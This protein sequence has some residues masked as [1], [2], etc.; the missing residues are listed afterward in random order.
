MS[1]FPIV[2]VQD[3]ERSARFYE[4]AFG[5]EPTFRWPAQGGPP[6]YV[7]L[8]RGQSH[9]GIGLGEGRGGF[10]LCLYVED[11]DATAEPQVHL[12]AEQRLGHLIDRK[13]GAH[14][15][16]AGEARIF[17]G[18][19]VHP[20]PRPCAVRGDEGVAADCLLPAR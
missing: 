18:K 16:L 4:D 5:F 20:Q 3:V 1:T 9:L 7:A 8:R 10:E 19:A 14:G 17:G 13:H 12:R 11:M 6:E 15:E 2:Y